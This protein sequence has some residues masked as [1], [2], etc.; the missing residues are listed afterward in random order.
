MSR[1]KA[2][3]VLFYSFFGFC[4]AQSLSHSVIGAAGD[5]FHSSNGSLDW[6]L[7]EIMTETYIQNGKMFTQGFQQTEI[8][9]D[10]LEKSTVVYPNPVRDSL[11]VRMGKNGSYQIEVYNILGNKLIDQNVNLTSSKVSFQID[12]RECS[13]ALYIL[14][15]FNTKTGQVFSFKIEKL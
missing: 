10:D 6:T 7:G 14:R 9:T 13:P 2:L 12:F 4:S 5:T 3:I 11:T 15:I 1:K 8:K